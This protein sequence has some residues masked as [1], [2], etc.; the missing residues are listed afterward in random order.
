MHLL[1][2]FFWSNKPQTQCLP[3]PSITFVIRKAYIS[4]VTASFP[5]LLCSCGN[6]LLL[7]LIKRSCVAEVGHDDCNHQCPLFKAANAHFHLTALEAVSS[8]GTSSRPVK[9]RTFHTWSKTEHN[10]GN[11]LR[12]LQN[13]LWPLLLLAGNVLISSVSQA[14]LIFLQSAALWFHFQMA[15]YSFAIYHLYK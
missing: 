5:S 2:L 8:P 11:L 7:F 4:A 14:L 1:S 3:S 15:T 10:P 12:S 9:P 13:G 6:T